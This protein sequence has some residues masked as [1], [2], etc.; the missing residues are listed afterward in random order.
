M[1]FLSSVVTMN[2]DKTDLGP[3]VCNTGYLRTQADERADDKSSDWR[4][5]S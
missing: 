5:K 3:F 1:L 4:E 2:A